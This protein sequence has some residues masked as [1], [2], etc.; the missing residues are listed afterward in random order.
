[1]SNTTG[2]LY[3]D[4]EVERLL[5]RYRRGIGKGLDITVDLSIVDRGGGFMDPFIEFWHQH[6]LGIHGNLRDS[7][8]YGQTHIDLPDGESYASAFGFGDISG[9]ITKQLSGNSL[10]TTAVKIP[11]GNPGALI[12]SGA[13]DAAFSL[14]TRFR[15]A[16]R[17]DLFVQL[18]EVFQGKATALQNSRPWVH[19]ESLSFVRHANRHDDWIVEWESEASAIVT[20]IPGSD[21]SQRS[22]SVGYRRKWKDRSIE[23]FF[24]EDGD[25]LNFRVPEVVNIAP[26]FT[27][28]VRYNLHF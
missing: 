11:T 3:E 24:T 19:Q 8:P 20:G 13:F 16:S 27:I 23:A 7:V 9:E 6:V 4:Y 18:G 2:S 17:L 28:G 14:Q 10:A 25:W 5:V 21:S 12:G 15:L 22:L 1:M 26:D